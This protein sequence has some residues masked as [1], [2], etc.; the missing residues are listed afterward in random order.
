MTSKFIKALI[1]GAPGSGKGTI[2]QR[3]IKDFKIN[4]FSSGDLLRANVLQ[5]SSNIIV[6][7]PAPFANIHCNIFFLEI[8][9]LVK[10]FI[11]KGQLVPDDVMVDLMRKELND[12]KSENILIDGRHFA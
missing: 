12:A 6:R 5:Q 9:V 10:A 8:G 4:H 3:I 2:S 7:H 11:D 1:I